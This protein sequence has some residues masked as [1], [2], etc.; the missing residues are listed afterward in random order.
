MA[1]FTFS[2]REMVETFGRDEVKN[3]FCNYELKDYLTDEEIAVINDRGTWSKEKLADKIIDHYYMHESGQE[4]P[5]LF[6]QRAKVAMQEIMESKLPLIYSASIKFNPLDAVDYQESYEATGKSHSENSG[7]G[8]TI[9]SDTPQ[10]KITK[11]D[12]LGGEYASATSGNEYTGNGDTQDERKY[13]RNIKG[14]K[15]KTMA[16]LI[17]QYRQNIIMIDRDIIKDLATLFH[18]VLV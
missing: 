5:A 1:T 2:M 3:W 10:G 11:T 17:Y 4:T 6:I 15:D 18:G 9:T 8:T 14:A 13:T 16:E 7:D 12:I